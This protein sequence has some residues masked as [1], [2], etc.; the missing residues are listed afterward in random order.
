[1]NGTPGDRIP[2]PTGP[3]APG[4]SGAE[5]RGTGLRLSPTAAA[6][7][8]GA[9]AAVVAIGA[10]ELIAGLVPGAPSLVAAIGQTVIDLQPPGAKDLVVTLFGQNDK[11][12]LEISIVAVALVIAAGL[13]VLARR[14][15]RAAALGF[16]AATVAGAG[17]AL[18]D[19]RADPILTVAAAAIAGAAA[20]QA[21]SW[22]LGAAIDRAGARGNPAAGSTTTMP[23][24]SRRTFLARSGATLAGAVVAG[25]V[26]RSQLDAQTRSATIAQTQLPHP[27]QVATLPAG[28]ALSVAGLTPIVVPNDTF[29]RIDTALLVPRVDVGGWRLR[30]HNLVERE[31]SLTF[32]QLLELGTFEQYVTIA[33]VSNTV[34]GDLVGNAKWTGIR[35]RDVLDIAGVRP[36]ASQLV[37]RAVDGWTAGMPTTWVMDRSRE[38]MIAVAMN[39]EPLPVVHGFPAR[40]IVPGLY[41]YVS[42]TKWL[43]ELEL[44]TLEAF[45]AY[46]VPLGWS[47]EAPVLTQSR[48]DVPGSRVVAGR[49][50]VAGVAWAP[51]RGISRVEVGI[52]GVWREATMST[53][54]SDATWVQWRTDWDATPGEHVLLV[55][56]TDGGGE[57]QTSQRSQPA[58]DG[59]RGY[60]TVRVNVG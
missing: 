18:R 43:S 8:G 55:R 40:L 46:W 34:G 45:D 22:L 53:P 54:I 23:D 60:H 30:V 38:A 6:A 20:I 49:V 58:P 27:S 29:Y 19:P 24:W 21:L 42:A 1:M 59:A 50:T 28:A 3:P 51:D 16:A 15:F 33:C 47:K 57:V 39:D 25:A 2:A 17:A 32:Q 4:G 10:S 44:T 5:R 36:E 48:I 13:G 41:G 12:A 14:S 35:L 31:T 26:G 7:L 9:I 52:D 56:A 37:G 11:L